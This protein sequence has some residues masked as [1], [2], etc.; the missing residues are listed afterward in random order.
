MRTLTDEEV[1]TRLNH[2]NNIFRVTHSSTKPTG[3]KKGAKNLTPDQREIIGTLGNLMTAR[4]VSEILPVSPMTV[5]LNSNGMH[6]VNDS[7]DD[8]LKNRINNNLGSAKDKALDLLMKS[9]GFITEEEVMNSK[10]MEKVMVAE[11]MASIVDK[12]TP[13]NIL[14]ENAN[15]HFHIHGPELKSESDFESIDVVAREVK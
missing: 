10:L 3:R 5:H 12:T 1:E 4:E 6:S 11:K 14:S 13:K 9:M 8:D 2:P 7:I 15:I